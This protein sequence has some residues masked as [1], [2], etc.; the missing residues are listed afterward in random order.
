VPPTT[1]PMMARRAFLRVAAGGAV[2]A[3]AGL[4]FSRFAAPRPA[5]G[6]PGAADDLATPDVAPGRVLVAYFSR[7]GENYFNGG[8][9][10]LEVGNTEVVAGMIG[11]LLACDVYRI[12]A[13]DPYPDGYDDTVARNVEE[14]EADA[15]PAIANPFDS[16]DRYETIL[17]GSPIWN[18]RAPMIMS[19]FTEGFDFRGRTVHPFTT[20]AISGLG[21]TERDY[22]ESCRGAT[23]GEGLA[24][25]GEE[26]REAEA[27]V[28]SWLRAIGLLQSA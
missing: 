28:E 21:T 20:Y 6:A 12:Q 4:A 11:R 26:V 5:P 23:I 1:Q 18:V 19:T 17:L 9:T 22:A 3:L 15:R 2:A 16:I 10:Y 13:A 24:I 25:Q 27:A 7:A 14:Q 8:R